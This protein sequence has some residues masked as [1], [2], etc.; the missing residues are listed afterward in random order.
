MAHFWISIA[1]FVALFKG[2]HSGEFDGDRVDGEAETDRDSK[3]FTGHDK[4]DA[5]EI[6]GEDIDG[7]DIDV[8]EP[9]CGDNDN[10]EFEGDRNNGEYDGQ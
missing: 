8:G 6:D 1:D 7:G 3:E 5:A 4:Y 10:G 2:E 9:D